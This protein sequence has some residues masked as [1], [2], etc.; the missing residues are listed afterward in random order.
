VSPKYM[1]KKL[2]AAIKANKPLRWEF[3][4]YDKYYTGIKLVA[5]SGYAETGR[6]YES[7]V[8]A[9][10]AIKG[11]RELATTLDEQGVRNA[12]FI[13][14]VDKFERHLAQQRRQAK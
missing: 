3:G 8:F 9:T 12:D 1:N 13:V 2:L 5:Y 10:T 11:A 4:D 6:V 14:A 7:V